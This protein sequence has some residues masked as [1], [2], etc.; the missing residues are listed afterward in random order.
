M[1]FEYQEYHHQIT[2]KEILDDLKRVVQ[3]NNL[4]SL[5]MKEYDELGTYDSSTVSRHFRTWNQA[6]QK[7]GIKINNQFWTE[8]ELFDNIE[9][10]WIAKCAQP[11][12]RDVDNK[13]ISTISSGAYI[14]KFGKWSNAL[15]AFVEYENGY[16][17]ANNPTILYEESHKTP[18]DVNYRLKFLVMKRDNFK[19]CICGASPSKNP[20]IELHID[21]K[22][23]WSKGGETEINNLQTLCSECNLGKSNL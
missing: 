3:E 10:V 4:V 7:A 19:C 23:P 2:D 1:K 12:R 9:K 20:N 21:H 15:K 18:R 5:T 16:D 22:I 11:S 17:I 14:R 8:E 6:L 13:N